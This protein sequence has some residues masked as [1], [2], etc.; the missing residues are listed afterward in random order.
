[1]IYENISRLC[2]VRGINICTLEREAGIGNG[3][4]GKWRTQSPRLDT[5]KKVADYF[6]VTVDEL[7]QEETA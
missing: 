3:V 5:V 6:N 2:R 1:M 7:M 4:V